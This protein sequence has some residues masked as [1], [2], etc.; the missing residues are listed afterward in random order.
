[1][2]LFRNLQNIRSVRIALIGDVGVYLLATILGFLSHSGETESSFGRMAATFFPFLLSW[3][4]IA[5]W[6]GAY[7]PVKM[8]DPNS[9]WHSALASLYAAPIGAF[10]RSLLLNSP[11]LPLFVII[12][13]GV[14]TGL[15]ILWRIFVTRVIAKPDVE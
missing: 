3:I 7:D 13:G 1:M 14:T 4:F 10:V 8:M 12:M 9:V 2:D 5:P 15:I 6:L 11:T